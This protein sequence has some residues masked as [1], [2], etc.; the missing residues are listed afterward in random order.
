LV[1]SIGPLLYEAVAEIDRIAWKPGV[2]ATTRVL[3]RGAKRAVA[4][5]AEMVVVKSNMVM[6][7]FE[8]MELI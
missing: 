6:K 5:V 3:R 8:N 2:G 4:M 1:A 7:L